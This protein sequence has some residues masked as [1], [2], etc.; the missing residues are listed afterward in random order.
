[1]KLPLFQMRFKNV[2]STNS[3]WFIQKKNNELW[4]RLYFFAAFFWKW[5]ENVKICR[6]TK[7][8]E[9]IYAVIAINLFSINCQ[10]WWI[11]TNLRQYPIQSKRLVFLTVANLVRLIIKIEPI[12]KSRLLM[13]VRTV[14]NIFCVFPFDGR[15]SLFSSF[16]NRSIHFK[17]P[18]YIEVGFAASIRSANG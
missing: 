7:I 4:S 6:N 1:M 2:W 15:F 14:I 16:A 18:N 12:I 3:A 13:K 11:E 9:Y 17:G 8:A 10:R 5:N